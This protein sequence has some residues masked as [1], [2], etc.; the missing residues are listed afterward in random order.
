MAVATK[1][2][3]LDIDGKELII[4]NPD[5]PLWPKAGVTKLI[6]LQ[7]LIQMAPYLLP[8]TTDRFLTVIRYPHGVGDKSF[9]QKNLPNYAPDWI[10]R[11]VDGTITYALLNDVATLVWMANQAVLEWHIAFHTSQQ[12][13]PTE[14]VFD[15]DPSTPDF[16]DAIEASLYVKEILD[17]LQLISYPKTSGASGIQVYIPIQSGYSFEQTRKVGEFICNYL[18]QKY[19]QKLTIERL[20]KNR[21]TKLY[22]DYLQHWRGKTLPAPYTTR[23]KEL[24]TVSAPLRWSEIEY[25]HPS[26]FTVHTMPA[27][28]KNKGDLFLPLQHKEN[29]ASLAHI[30]EILT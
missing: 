21:G 24:A 16:D 27:R 10:P 5:K 17:E 2:Y 20:T 8:Y 1:E 19:P 28:V 22:L 3:H 7:Y 11:A 18:T 25:A 14:L 4:T 26:D 30:L 6:Y 9:Y 15:L 12:E 29:R 13:W 23:A